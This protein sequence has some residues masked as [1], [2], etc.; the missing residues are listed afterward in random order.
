MKL[1]SGGA[2]S[3]GRNA[4]AER[5]TAAS[6]GAGRGPKRI[7]HGRWISC[8]ATGVTTRYPSAGACPSG[9][10]ATR[11]RRCTRIVRPAASDNRTGR[12]LNCNGPAPSCATTTCSERMSRRK[13]TLR[14]ATTWSP[15]QRPL[16][17]RPNASDAGAAV[18]SVAVAPPT[19]IRPAPC[20]ATGSPASGRA[21]PTR[22]PFSAS[23]SRYG[24]ACARSAAPP[25]TS[26]AATLVPLTVPKRAEPSGFVPG[27]AVS[28]AT[29]GAT[30][31]GL[32]RASNASP[33]DENCATF[34]SPPFGVVRTLPSESAAP[35]PRR[36]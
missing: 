30:T 23:A 2:A 34:P 7:V 13:V 24:R 14:R 8:P 20:D 21:E 18:T 19:S 32:T 33:D 9:L 4:C 28:S 3:D 11:T 27:S 29:P 17:A 10:P 16:V 25:P 35:T 12:M 26:A 5:C 6:V 15:C 1:S 22:S 31:S 36:S